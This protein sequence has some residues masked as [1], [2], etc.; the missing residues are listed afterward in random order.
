MTQ[1]EAKQ[2]R[3]KRTSHPNVNRNILFVVDTSGSIGLHDFERVISVLANYTWS[4]CGDNVTIGLMTFGEFIH[5][6]F[7]PKCYGDKDQRVYLRNISDKIRG[8]EY[9]HEGYT[10]TAGAVNCLINRI[11]PNQRCLDS[12]PTQIVFFTDGR[13]NRCGS[14]KT[15]IDQLERVFGHTTLEVYGIGMGNIASSG[16]TE[17]LYRNS[18]KNIFNVRDISELEKLLELT[19]SKIDDDK[20]TCTIYTDITHN[21]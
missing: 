18:E 5:L 2:K 16:V 4:L 13:A 12:K 6:E 19:S 17:L 20:I 1:N 14:V 3:T 15:A 11:L 8:T 9:H 7:C 10:S 21:Q